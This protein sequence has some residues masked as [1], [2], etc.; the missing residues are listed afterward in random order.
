MKILSVDQARNGA[1]CVYDYETAKPIA[2]GTFNF[3]SDKFPFGET[4]VK[5]CDVVQ[6]VILEHRVSAVFIEDTQMRKNP[7]SF[8]KLSQ[9][10]G[11]LIAMFERNEYLYDIVAPSTWQNFCN[12]RGRTSKEVK[13][14]LLCVDVDTKKKSKQLSIQFAKEQFGIETTDDNLADSICLGYYVCSKISIKKTEL[15]EK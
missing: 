14:E 12:A 1:W 15:K 9:L 6:D 11:A 5:I 3:P 10:Q 8:K 13:A 7:D 2:Y 4:L